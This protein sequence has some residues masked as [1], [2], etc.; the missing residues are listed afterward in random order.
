MKSKGLDV[1]YFTAAEAEGAAEAFHRDGFACVRD[2]LSPE[3]LAFAQKGASRVI[4]EQL[5]AVGAEN[6]NRG[7]A[8]HSFGDQ[9]RHP[10]WA[11]LVDLPTILPILEAIWRSEEF[12]CMGAGGDYSLPGARIQRLHSDMG[13]FLHDPQGLSTFHDLPA[14]FIVVN[15]PMTDF[16]PLNGAIRF[17][18][19]TQR[20]RASAPPLESEPVWMQEGLLCAPAGSAIIRDVRCWHG[21]TANNSASPRPMTSVGYY[22]P[23]FRAREAQVLPLDLYQT[24]S[25]RAQKLCRLL[26]DS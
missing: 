12:T 8:R 22:A 16:T 2:A 3:Q 10:E 13:E 20:S 7:F 23:W 11:M 6:M 17:V 15:F 1:E 24:L 5:A 4:A 26:R 21:G 19:C 14:P 18:P 25:P 9:I